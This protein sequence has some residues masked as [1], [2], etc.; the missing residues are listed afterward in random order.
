MALSVGSKVGSYEVL[1]LLGAGGMGEVYRARDTRLNREVAI[2]VLPADR[3]SDEGRRRRFVHEAQSASA[4]NHPH[5]VTI[6]EIES[7]AERDFIVMEYV[8]GRSL[9]ALIPRGGMRL[10]ELLRI[11]IPVA[12]ALGAAHARGII[13]RDLKPA[14]VIVGTEG[15]VKVLDFGL[16]KLVGAEAGPDDATDT[17]FANA[18]LS[19]P[20]AIAGTAAYMS[21]EQATGGKVDGRSDVFSF[22]AMVY[23]MATGQRPF[24]GESSAEIL[25]AVIRAQ[26][27]PP[28]EMA[29]A[30]PRELERVILR[31]LRREPERRFQTMLDVKIELQEIKEAWDS[32]A[33]GAAAVPA[34][35]V[36]RTLLAVAGAI[37]VTLLASAVWFLWR[38]GAPVAPS[39]IV[40][41]TTLTGLEFDPSLSPDGEQVAFAWNG[42]KEER[43]NVYVK[44]VGSSD[45]RQLTTGPEND[46][47]PAWSPDGRQIAFVRYPDPLWAAPVRA[48]IYLVSPVSGVERK[49]ADFPAVGRIRWS[50][51][52]QWLAVG[53]M[54]QPPEEGG[55]YLIP[56]QGGE[57]RSLTRAARGRGHFEPA[58]SPDGRSLAYRSCGAAS[59]DLEVLPMDETYQPVG[60]VRRLLEGQK[61]IEG[62]IW[63]E[64][65]RS[66]LYAQEP[67]PANVRLWRLWVDGRRQ[68]E[69]LDLAGVGAR[70]PTL[71]G[72]RLAFALMRNTVSIHPLDTTLTSAAIVSSTFWDYHPAFSPDGG[73][74][75]FSSSRS[76]DAVQIWLSAAD[77]SRARQLTYGPSD[78]QGSPSWSPDGRRIAFD[79]RHADGSW[80]IWTI[81]AAGGAPH[82]LTT[83]PGDQF[84]PSWSHDGRWIYYVFEQGSGRDVWRIPVGGGRAL[85]VTRGGSGLVYPFE[86]PDGTELFYKPAN[87]E[88]PLMAAALAKGRTRQVLPCLTDTFMVAGE[89]IYY[90][91]CGS[92]P[93]RSLRLHHTVTGE[94]RVLGTVRDIPQAASA[95]PAVSP[96]GQTILVHR[97][98]MTSDLMLIDNFR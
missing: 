28:T 26:P 82:Q 6:Y 42:E 85:Q 13:H 74:I 11:A 76:G 69:R 66:L 21:P 19:A 25:A 57:P 98:A 67:A 56:A 59:C 58:F 20:G 52:G 29:G 80:S 12:D 4:L 72:S 30:L 3:L 92:G 97:S 83:E 79:S 62:V 75:A 50:P 96:D 7:A 60:A 17:H 93:R 44:M 73:Q 39:A 36:S 64:A 46:W 71:R 18:A 49:V 63:D 5:I 86:S 78:W 90:A 43:F 77:G 32:A 9:D 84:M 23:E 24:R 45:V 94:N 48:A 88:G 16:A 70:M 87:G 31:C 41:L 1:S 91:E 89:G 8:R 34:R 54:P 35:R 38:P 33:F 40:P 47:R 55:I 65:G 81:E 22:G 95:R 37:A 51:D 15:A 68:P 2:K 53:R 10:G 14:N 61:S 27:S